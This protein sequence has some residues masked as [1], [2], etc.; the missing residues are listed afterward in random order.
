M[1]KSLFAA[2]TVIAVNTP[3]AQAVEFINKDGSE[4][5]ELCIAAVQTET[6]V[7]R[8]ETSDVL[9]NDM[10]LR[11]FVKQY[12]N[13]NTQTNAKAVTFEKANSAPEAELCIA[14]ATSNEAFAQISAGFTR[15][16]INSVACNGVELVKFAKRYNKSFNG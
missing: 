6:R 7:S 11:S 10:N 9:C 14:A 13:T 15:T 5:S 12:R 3:V 2:V 8:F 4:L 1:L 16:T